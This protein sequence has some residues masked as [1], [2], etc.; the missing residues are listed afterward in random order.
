MESEH[1]IELDQYF[2]FLDEICEEE[3][4]IVISKCPILLTKQLIQ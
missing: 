3:T 2:E 1:D 4:K